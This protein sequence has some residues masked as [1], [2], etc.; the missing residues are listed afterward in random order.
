MDAGRPDE[1]GQRNEER[2]GEPEGGVG[3]NGRDALEVA[4]TSR[5]PGRAAEDSVAEGFLLLATNGADFRRIQTE[6]GGVGREVALLCPHLMNTASH[7][8]AKAHEGMGGE[9]EGK[10]IV[11]RGG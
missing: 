10:A 1:G 8:F 9:V 5:G 4:R 11:R 2:R 6:P 7:E 3:G